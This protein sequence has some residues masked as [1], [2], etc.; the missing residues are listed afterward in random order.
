MQV[1]T[2]HDATGSAGILSDELRRLYDG[3]LSFRQE[4]ARPLIVGNFVQTLDGIVSLKI[5]GRSGGGEIS[6][7]NEEDTF[8]MGLLR[9]CAD[10]VLIGEET[11]R[12][13][14][15]H[16]WT[17]DFIC[18]KLKDEYQALRRRLQKRS[19]HPLTVIASGKGSIELTGAL[20]K[21]SEVTAVI[22]TTKAG[23]ERIEH[24][25]GTALPCDIQVLP[26]DSVLNPADMA[27]LLYERYGVK[28]LLHEGG[29]MLF[30]SFL[31][32][33]LVDELFL[34]IAPQI[35]GRGAMGERPAFSGQLSFGPGDARWGALLSIKTAVTGHLFLRYWWEHSGA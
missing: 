33:H 35:V 24:K 28:L 23:K 2:L 5:P 16:L 17:A 26:G 21:Q 34:T 10:A 12:V 18:P 27:S 20:F 19:L 15:K 32:D 13:A 14:R 9:S 22:L 7:R 6:G 3:N 30:A 8:I 11:Y 4:L 29:P 31:Q 25:H 1:T